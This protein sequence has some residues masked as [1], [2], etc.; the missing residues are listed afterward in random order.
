M[1]KTNA[2]HKVQTDL[3]RLSKR[4]VAMKLTKYVRSQSQIEHYNQRLLKEEGPSFSPASKQLEQLEIHERLHVRYKSNEL[5]HCLLS[6]YLECMA[7]VCDLQIKVLKYGYKDEYSN[8]IEGRD[9]RQF[10][11][12]LD[13]F[14][15]EFKILGDRGFYNDCIRYPNLNQQIVP[16]LLEGRDQFSNKELIEDM[17]LCRLRYSSETNFSRI[18][19]SNVLCDTIPKNHSDL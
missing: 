14:P 16:H 1:R 6:K 19:D 10:Y 8:I 13:K 11:T 4:K 9:V 17:K 5:S 3:P 7:H 2:Y 18:T 12:R 15:G